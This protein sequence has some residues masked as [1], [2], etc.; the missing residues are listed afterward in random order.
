MPLSPIEVDV[1]ASPKI[2]LPTELGPLVM[3]AFQ[4]SIGRAERE[5]RLGEI[6]S[7]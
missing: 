6:N 3:T 1:E 5:V 7:R 4:D 2:R